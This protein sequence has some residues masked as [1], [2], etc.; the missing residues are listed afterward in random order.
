M[1]YQL[2]ADEFQQLLCV[3]KWKGFCRKYSLS[4][5]KL[6]QMPE[7]S[8]QIFIILFLSLS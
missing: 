4:F 5:K 2:N 1:L 7:Q 6:L 3:E 8:E